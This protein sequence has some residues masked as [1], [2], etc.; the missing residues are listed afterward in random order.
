MHM[1]WYHEAEN[2][3]N[4]IMSSS[5][6]LHQLQCWFHVHLHH[7]YLVLLVVATTLGC[8]C[9]AESRRSVEEVASGDS[10]MESQEGSDVSLRGVIVGEAEF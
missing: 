6:L 2:E 5:C 10:L 4:A 7:L 1:V 8:S 9:V 3:S